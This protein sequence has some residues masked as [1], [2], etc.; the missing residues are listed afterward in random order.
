MSDLLVAQ[1]A[2]AEIEERAEEFIE[3]INPLTEEQL[4]FSDE[5]VVNSIGTLA[6]HMTG[7]FNHFFG[8]GFLKNGYVR[9]RDDEFS[10]KIMPKAQVIVDLQAGVD[11]VRQGA[12]AIDEGDVNKP[13]RTPCGRDFVSLGDHIIHL[14][15][16]FAHHHGQVSYAIRYIA[17]D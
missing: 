13:Y 7:N 8:A 16:H 3:M 12:A 17:R 6:R 14:V 2:V 10:G 15:T 5:V 11:I 9:D 1:L 4:W